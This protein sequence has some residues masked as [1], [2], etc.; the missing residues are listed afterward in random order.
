MSDK[1]LLS[2]SGG[3]DSVLALHNL[4][5]LGGYKVAGLITTFTESTGTVGLHNVPIELIR[6]QA[7][8][9]DLPLFEIGL[10]L[11]ASNYEYEQRLL[12]LFENAKQTGISEVAFGDIYL[13]SIREYRDNLALKTRMKF[14]Y[15]VWGQDT[16]QLSREFISRG[17]DAI[18]IAIQKD[19]IAPDMLGRIF[20]E[21]FIGDLPLGVDVCGE[22]GEFH[23]FVYDGPIFNKPIPFRTGARTVE[24]SR[25]G[26]DITMEYLEILP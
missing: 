23:T 9:L 19:L 16:A 26:I 24:K 15:P 13:A 17:Y 21:S 2:W 25:Q 6:D 1:I 8:S 10:T 3:K 7:D 11:N 4:L 22:N 12:Q 5:Y 20:D 18:V 14:H